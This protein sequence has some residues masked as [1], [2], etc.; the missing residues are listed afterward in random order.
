M[1][2]KTFYANSPKTTPGRMRKIIFAAIIIFFITAIVIL[3]GEVIIR[4][5]APQVYI[6]PKWEFSPA[7]GHQLFK[8]VVMT[9]AK[10]GHWKFLYT[11]NEYRYRG[12]PVPIR[13][14]YDRANIVILGDSNAFGQ[15][16]N[17]GEEFASV[18]ADELGDD[19]NVINLSVGG[20]GLT[21]EIRRYYQFGAKYQP[22]AVILQLCNNDIIDNVKNYVTKV[23]NGRF[24]FQNSQYRMNRFKTLLSKSPVQ[25]SQI[26]NF[27]RNLFYPAMEREFIKE[28]SRYLSNGFKDPLPFEQSLFI[29]LLETFV[30]EMH[31]NNIKLLIISVGD[32]MDSFPGI[33][34]KI[35][36]LEDENKIVYLD[37][38]KWLNY[39][40]DY[41]SPEGHAWD[42][43]AH[44]IIGHC[45]ADIVRKNWS[46]SD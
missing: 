36:L 45:L 5:F 16:V 20:W 26:Y 7:Y 6:F 24:V 15:G 17:D 14:Q 9:H 34:G 33:R 18:M 2:K 41:R 39:M 3:L 46:K 30:R 35:K 37:T 28:Q 42:R 25:K 4:I 38:R 29:K 1:L 10:P 13:P 23:D 12:K 32:E 44:N 27:V 40:R 22:V 43:R 8:N 21:Q 11:I 19:Y 31:K